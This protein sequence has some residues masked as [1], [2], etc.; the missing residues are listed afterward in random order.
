M[1][2]F[3]KKMARLALYAPPAA[4][5]AVLPMMHNLLRR[6]GSCLS[7]LHRIPESIQKRSVEDHLADDPFDMDCADPSECNA[8]ASSLWELEA[9][10]S[11]YFVNVSNFVKTFRKKIDNRQSTFE[12]DNFLNHSYHDLLEEEFELQMKKTPALAF[13]QDKSLLFG[14]Q[15]LIRQV[16]MF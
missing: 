2:A 8:T 12:I 4:I 10:E 7:L 3:I 11:H 14:N 15:D 6:H 5:L 13:H 16:W 1:A 9:L